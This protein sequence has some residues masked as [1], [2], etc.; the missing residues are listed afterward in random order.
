MKKLPP[1]TIVP[2]T[3]YVERDADRQ[4]KRNLSEMGRPAYVLVAR[5]MGKTN[6]LLHAKRILQG[7]E[8]LFVYVDLSKPFESAREC[9]RLIIDTA[10]D[11]LHSRRQGDY[12]EIINER[13]SEQ[14]AY[15]EHDRELRR[16]LR[17]IKG[18]LVIILCPCPGL[19]DYQWVS[20][21]AWVS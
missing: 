4:T 3:L 12:H 11:Q 2:E 14:P 13:G 20:V 9:F 5:Q 8:D 19:V 10:L 21:E 15:R 17:S 16:V 1:L 7:A 6:L 18:K